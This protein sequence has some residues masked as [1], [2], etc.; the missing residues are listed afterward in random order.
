LVGAEQGK[1]PHQKGELSEEARIFFVACTRSA[2]TLQISF[3]NSH[4]MF[5]NNYVGK[6]RDYDPGVGEVTEDIMTVPQG[7]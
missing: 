2:E 3:S 6:I 4:S 1:L 5:L 7:A